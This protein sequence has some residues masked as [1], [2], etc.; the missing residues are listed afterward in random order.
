MDRIDHSS[1]LEKKRN[2]DCLYKIFTTIRTMARQ[3][4]AFRGDGN[5]ESSNL[6]QILSMRAEDDITLPQWLA[7]KSN[8]WTSHDIQDEI[9]KTLSH[10]VLREIL[11]EVQNAAF[12]AIIIDETSDAS[13]KEQLSFVVRVVSDNLIPEEYFL[14]F[15]ELRETSANFLFNIVKDIFARFQLDIQKLRGQC[16]DGASN[17]SGCKNGLQAKIL[18]QEHRAIY[19]HCN[20]HNLNLVVQDAVL[21]VAWTRDHIGIAKEIITFVRDSPK[22]LTEFESIQDS[23]NGALS[24]FC[25]TRYDDQFLSFSLH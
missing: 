14:G 22:R 9:L 6:F 20:A 16:F 21:N 19:V 17:M 18:E 3:G 1:A 23:D 15:Y 4:L 11:K 25:P 2:R 10:A 13:R 5:E 7:S 8:K 24:P 12:F